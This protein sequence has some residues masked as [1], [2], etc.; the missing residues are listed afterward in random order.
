MYA[1]RI[2]ITKPQ[3]QCTVNVICIVMKCNTLQ[4]CQFLHDIRVHGMY[5]THIPIDRLR[6]LKSNAL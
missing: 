3:L 2:P 6:R 4:K 5:S 1:T